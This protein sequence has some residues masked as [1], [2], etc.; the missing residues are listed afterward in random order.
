MPGSR[1]H[2]LPC[3][4]CGLRLWG[5]VALNQHLEKTHTQCPHCPGSYIRVDMHIRL[6]HPEQEP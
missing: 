6:S 4:L 2:K 5:R 1:S 3:P